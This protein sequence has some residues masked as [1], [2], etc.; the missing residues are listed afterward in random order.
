MLKR[1]NA[2]AADASTRQTAVQQIICFNFRGSDLI[3]FMFFSFR[4][5][6]AKPVEE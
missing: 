6:P 3:L 4:R 2:D 1:G 5:L